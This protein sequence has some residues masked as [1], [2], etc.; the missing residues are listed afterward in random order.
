MLED[1]KTWLS[2][3][4]RK[5]SSIK[6]LLQSYKRLEKDGICFTSIASVQDYILFLKTKDYSSSHINTVVNFIRDYTHYCDE[7]NIT[8]DK[9]L[10]TLKFVKDKYRPRATMSDDEINSFLNIPKGPNT[11]EISFNYWRTFFSIMAYTGMRTGE[12]SKLKV[13]NVDFSQDVF[14]LIDTKTNEDRIVPI[15]TNIKYL[16]FDWVQSVKKG[17]L[18]FSR[19]PDGHCSNVEWNYQFHVR[20]KKLGI[21]RFNLTPYSL[22]HS[23]IT[24]MLQTDGVNI[25]DVKNLVGHHDTRTTENYYH[26]TT[27]RLKAVVKKHPGVRGSTTP[28]EIFKSIEEYIEGLGLDQRFK[29]EKTI[30]NDGI[31]IDIKV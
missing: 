8:Y 19:R 20:I 17:Y 21:T 6:N 9:E 16:V 3:T 13:Q 25:F 14:Y 1:F 12:V 10:C 26:L 22:R 7:K 29:L 23:Y 11:S 15:P 4:Q 2:S 31:K 27:K 18:F 5:P 28:Q 24:E 30:S